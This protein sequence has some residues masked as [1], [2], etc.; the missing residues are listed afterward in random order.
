MFTSRLPLTLVLSLVFFSDGKMQEDKSESRK[1]GKLTEGKFHAFDSSAKQ[2]RTHW[3]FV[4]GTGGP[5]AI[6][7]PGNGE[8]GRTEERRWNNLPKDRMPNNGNFALIVTTRYGSHIIDGVV[9]KLHEED[10]ANVDLHQIT[11]YGQSFGCEN[12]QQYMA[13]STDKRI[14]NFLCSGAQMSKDVIATLNWKKYSGALAD[15]LATHQRTFWTFVSRADTIIPP[16]PEEGTRKARDFVPINEA[17]EKWCSMY[18]N[19]SHA[20][21]K[22]ELEGY[23]TQLTEVVNPTKPLNDTRPDKVKEREP[24]SRI[25]RHTVNDDCHVMWWEMDEGK[26]QFLRVPFMYAM[27][28]KLMVSHDCELPSEEEFP[29]SK[30]LRQKLLKQWQ[31]KQ[32]KKKNN[33]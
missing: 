20:H 10:Y 1:A 16:Y 17:M 30:Q 31:E 21:T 7:I 6:Y 2:M 9:E 24:L 33:P 27:L 13:K 4:W 25:Y 14:H 22:V 29:T 8:D 5:V 18:Q 32:Q 23:S 3:S 12:V 28:A 11:L 26:H 19:S 15:H